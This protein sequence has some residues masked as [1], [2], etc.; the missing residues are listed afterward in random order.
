[1]KNTT[2]IADM[3]ESEKPCEKI[4]SMGAEVM[5]DAELLSIILRTGTDRISVIG[6]AQ[7]IL[8]LHPVYKGVHGLN[9]LSYHDLKS[10]RGVGKVKA[11]QIMALAELSRRMNSESFKPKM[12]F[13][14]PASIADYFMEKVRYL[15]RERVYVLFL[16]T[17]NSILREMVLSEGSV[18]QSIM[19]PR[20]LF[21][22]ALRCDAVSIILMHN[23][24]SGNPEPSTA[25]V[26]ITSKISKL[27]DELGI[28]LLD[29]I[30]IG[31]K[32]Y[33]SMRERDLL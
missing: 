32:S 7:Q 11:A 2:R 21:C 13:N 20:E 26:M 28:A 14:S 9:Y 30:I 6:L 31:D 5:S 4:L 1:M 15:T 18:N 10:V 16:S 25:D 29:H 12:T 3:A 22:E 17:N 27:G 24:P 8:N 33:V 23:H 19:S